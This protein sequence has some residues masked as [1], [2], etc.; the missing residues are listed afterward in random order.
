MSEL[1]QS[2][3][4]GATQH[5]VSGGNVEWYRLG[6][7]PKDGVISNVSVYAF[8]KNG[9]EDVVVGLYAGSAT[10]PSGDAV[11]SNTVNIDTLG[12]YDISGFSA[13]YSAG[14]WVWLALLPDALGFACYRNATPLVA[15]QY[16]TTATYPT[17]PN[18]SGL[19]HYSTNELIAY[20]SYVSVTGTI[21]DNANQTN[22]FSGES[23]Q[24]GALTVV[25]DIAGIDTFVASPNYA[26]ILAG[27]T[28]ASSPTNGWNN[29]GPTL[30]SGT[31]D[32]DT[33]VTLTLNAAGSYAPGQTEVLSLSIPASELAG[34]SPIAVADFATI[35][36][37]AILIRVHGH[38]N[39]YGEGVTVSSY[40][41]AFGPNSANLRVAQTNVKLWDTDQWIDVDASDGDDY[42][43][44][45]VP[46][47]ALMAA[48]YG[49]GN[50]YVVRSAVNSIRLDQSGSLSNFSA[51]QYDNAP[52]FSQLKAM[53]DAES[54]AVLD[55]TNG[56]YAL[57]YDDVRII[58]FEWI[59]SNDATSVGAAARFYYNRLNFH[60]REYERFGVAP[61]YVGMHPELP[62]ATGTL[63]NLMAGDLAYDVRL[64]QI[65]AYSALEALTGADYALVEQ[66][67]FPR[68]SDGMHVTATGM[69]QAAQALFDQ[70]EALQAAGSGDITAGL[71][72]SWTDNTTFQALPSL[73]WTASNTPDYTYAAGASLTGI[74]GNLTNFGSNDAQDIE[75]LVLD[76]SDVLTSLGTSASPET[77]TA[78]LSD[79]AYAPD[80]YYGQIVYAACKV[81]VY[82]AFDYFIV[83]V[84]PSRATLEGLSTPP[85]QWVRGAETPT[86]A[87]EFDGTLSAVANEGSQTF[88]WSCSGSP[89]RTRHGL[90]MHDG[91]ALSA[92]A[93][94]NNVPQNGDWYRFLKMRVWNLFGSINFAY[95]GLDGFNSYQASIGIARASDLTDRDEIELTVLQHGATAFGEITAARSSD[96]WDYSDTVICLLTYDDSA[97][98]LTLHYRDSSGN[99][100]NTT[101]VNPSGALTNSTSAPDYFGYGSVRSPY[102]TIIEAGAG[103]YLPSNTEIQS[104]FDEL[105]LGAAPGAIEI[106]PGIASETDG[107]QPIGHAA[108]HM[109]GIATETD[110]GQALAHQFS[111]ALGVA[112]ETDSAQPISTAIQVTLGIATETDAAQALTPIVGHGFQLAANYVAGTAGTPQGVPD[113]ATTDV[114]EYEL[115]T[116]TGW[117]VDFDD[118]L[119]VSYS[120]G[121][122]DVGTFDIWLNDTTDGS[123]SGPIT[124]SGLV[125]T[126]IQ[127]GIATE[128][129]LAQVLLHKFDYALGIAS[130]SDSALSIS[131]QNNYSIGVATE[132]NSALALSVQQDINV[133]IG[134]AGETDSAAA[135]LQGQSYAI[136]VASESNVA[137]PISQPGEILVAIGVASENDSAQSVSAQVDINIVLGVASETDL[138]QPASPRVDI[139][140]SIGIAVETNAAQTLTPTIDTNVALGAAIES[141]TA[142]IIS[143]TKYY[144][145]F[146]DVDIDLITIELLSA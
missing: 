136:G 66:W 89:K 39:A 55:G 47:A 114:L 22:V 12:F 129:S 103:A 13:S 19:S 67:G 9:A 120:G 137:Q 5:V 78:D 131:Q 88:D 35:T 52:G 133:A 68:A 46:L 119:R 56:L 102:A 87:T 57:G 40:S 42:K 3:I 71:G 72:G 94:A 130:E 126:E 115:T 11:D 26:N 93:D 124:V 18:A 90:S 36:Y 74:V 7:M 63:A 59:G 37:A 109:L 16:T 29:S 125:S 14:D 48:K 27:I 118:Q 106:T 146:P 43:G 117:G 80:K 116:T 44:L 112:A 49:D 135:V 98:E 99:R 53:L 15:D 145:P 76:S 84:L 10:A 61:P 139:N 21:T 17:L 113:I 34:S 28:A 121:T 110:T 122:G 140:L 31:R 75:W 134:I 45:H 62:T 79:M 77:A 25:V 92:Q 107:A 8:G 4:T 20:V 6:Q 142:Q 104:I 65:R 83:D 69:E 82:W 127:I 143:F 128:S 38:S 86:F 95:G 73:S 58:N 132:T 141:S 85:F 64:H 81:G 138:T 41:T 24:N 30:A 2:S 32:S 97:N 111:L 100:Q 105:A 23:H 33:Q 60:A 101:V 91:S 51:Y 123:R 108:S 70:W 50:C 144:E 1:G 96:L 54:A